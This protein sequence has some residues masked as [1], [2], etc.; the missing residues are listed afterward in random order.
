[1]CSR[2]A[3]TYSRNCCSSTTGVAF[4][5]QKDCCTNSAFCRRRSAG[6]TA[7]VG[8]GSC[9]SQCWLAGWPEAGSLGS[10]RG[11]CHSSHCSFVRTLGL[12]STDCCT[13]QLCGSCSHVST[14]ICP[15]FY[16]LHFWY[17]DRAVALHVQQTRGTTASGLQ[18]GIHGNMCTA[19]VL[20]APIYGAA[21]RF[22]GS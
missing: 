10:A 14:Q 8:E 7:V 21:D 11:V 2:Q 20:S 15:L 4:V 9:V 16:S 1:M 12:L 19:A 5:R 3:H 17:R 22:S 18:R 6:T 13:K